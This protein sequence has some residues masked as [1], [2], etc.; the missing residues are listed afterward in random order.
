MVEELVRKY[1]FDLKQPLPEGQDPW[2]LAEKWVTDT[3]VLPEYAPDL[4]K[5]YKYWS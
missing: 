3:E 2:I 5:L 1:S 4:G